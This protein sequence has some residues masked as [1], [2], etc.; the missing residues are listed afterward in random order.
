M[1]KNLKDIKL[2]QEELLDHYNYP[3]NR[4]EKILSLDYIGVG[5]NPS[6]GDAVSI[7]FNLTDNIINKILFSGSGC[8]ISQATASML[9][10][11]CNNKDLNFINNL[12]KDD[13]LKL[14][15]I[16]LGPNRL[17]CALLSLEALQQAV[18][19]VLHAK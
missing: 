5:K 6:C 10:Q 2:Y 13:I 16:E 12:N 7:G 9:T 1:N 4:C 3:K 18:K 14:I 17:R 19:V 11:L 15:G 8:V